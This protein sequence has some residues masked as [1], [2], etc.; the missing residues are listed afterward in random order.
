[1]IKVML[2]TCD[3]LRKRRIEIGSI[4]KSSVNFLLTLLP[5]YSTIASNNSEVV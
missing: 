5:G 2:N 4:E 1:M 3:L